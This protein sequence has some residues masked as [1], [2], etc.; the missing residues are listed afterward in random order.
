VVL[1][2]HFALVSVFANPY[3]KNKGKIDYYAEW[4]VYPYFTQNWNLFVPPP[5][6]NY[7]LFAEYQDY[8][9]QRTD[10]FQELVLKHQANRL[11][12]HGSVLLAFSNTIHYFEKNTTLQQ[13]LNSVKN[14]LYFQ[15]IE[16][17]AL[18]Y[19]QHAR[20]IKI[21]S[22]KIRLV[23]QTLGSNSDKVYFN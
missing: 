13:P 8:G 21:D 11:K 16:K 18:N 1:C 20:G 3:S 15:M 23:V 4:Y 9:K 22:L 12:G 10:I 5:N 14:D 19:L 6:T 2:I 7:T 17:S